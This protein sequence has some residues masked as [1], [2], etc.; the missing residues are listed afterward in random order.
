M[1]NVHKEELTLD[2][3]R[4]RTKHGDVLRSKVLTSKSV[5]PFT[6]IT[7]A[8]SFNFWYWHCFQSEVTTHMREFHSQDSFWALYLVV[9]LC[10]WVA[11]KVQLDDQ[12]VMSGK[13]HFALH[14]D[15]FSS[16]AENVVASLAHTVARIG[17]S[18][19][20]ISKTA[21]MIAMFVT[22]QKQQQEV[23]LKRF[24]LGENFQQAPRHCCC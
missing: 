22:H 6:A 23:H 4:R 7:E 8:T 1:C 19:Q 3:G 5:S 17:C 2:D 16:L 21:Q 13:S 14:I 11:F 24:N 9:P 18:S 12:V 15:K 20:H 10:T